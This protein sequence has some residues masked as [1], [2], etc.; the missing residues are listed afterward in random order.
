[1]ITLRKAKTQLQ[2]AIDAASLGTW[3]LDPVTNSFFGERQAK[4]VV[5]AKARTCDR[6]A[7]GY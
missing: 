1:M 5:W 7:K 4:V 6:P 2:F 3:D